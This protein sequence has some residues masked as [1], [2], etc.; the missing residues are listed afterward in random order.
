TCKLHG[1][2]MRT[3]P[4]AVVW[5]GSDHSQEATQPFMMLVTLMEIRLKAG[6]FLSQ[7]KVCRMS[8][9]WTTMRSSVERSRGAERRSEREGERRLG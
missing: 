8:S 9:S 6:V 2:Q 1:E 7:D 5:T 4:D 3:S